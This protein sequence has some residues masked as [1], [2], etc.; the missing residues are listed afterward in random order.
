MEKNETYVI[1]L[2]ELSLGIHEYDFH[3][4]DSFFEEL[5]AT[6]VRK[7]SV[8][9]KVSVK[10]TQHSF[11]LHFD[12]KGVVMIPCDRCLEDM[13]QEIETSNEL[14]VKYGDEFEEVDDQLIVIPEYPGE[15][16]LA[17]YMYE[18]IALDIP[19]RH[20]H[21]NGEC[22][23]EMASQLNRYMTVE[24][25]DEDDWEDGSEDEESEEGEHEIDPRWESL[26]GLLDKND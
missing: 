26:K 17:W 25:D 1:S 4:D 5:D 15:I 19:I 8:D 10:K 22:S 18:F 3:L 2:R 21:P 23:G 6:E 20:V 11:N 16:D 12:S 24:V 9:V 13:E 14:V 7:G